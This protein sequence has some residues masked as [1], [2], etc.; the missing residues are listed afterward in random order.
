VFSEA[1]QTFALAQAPNRLFLT[2]LKRGWRVYA[3]LRARAARTSSSKYGRTSNKATSV[4]IENLIRCDCVV[5]SH[6]V[7]ANGRA[8]ILLAERG[9]L[10]LQVEEP[11]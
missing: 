1:R 10:A 7:S 8:D 4:C 2:A 11:A 3:F 5:E 6:N 9:Y